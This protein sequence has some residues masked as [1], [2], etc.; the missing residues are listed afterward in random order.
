[1]AE[2]SGLTSGTK[3]SFAKMMNAFEAAGEGSSPEANESAKKAMERF[4]KNNKRRGIAV[5]ATAAGLTITGYNPDMDKTG[6]GARAIVKAAKGGGTAIAMSRKVLAA[7]S[8]RDQELKAAGKSFKAKKAKPT[9]KSGKGTAGGG[10]MK[11][12]K[13]AKP[14][15]K[16]K[17]G[18][19]KAVAA[20]PAAKGDGKP[21]ELEL[22]RYFKSG[23]KKKR[24]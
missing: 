9:T 1:M 13:M 14:K 15:A 17:K 18:S 20:K 10:A 21:T 16:A 22:I 24:K 12:A 23:G 5:K 4:I 2:G 8:A 7:A 19:V 11:S 3:G 6:T